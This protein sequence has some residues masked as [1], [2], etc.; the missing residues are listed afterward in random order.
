MGELLVFAGLVAAVAVIGIGA[1]MLVAGR[2]DQRVGTD[3]TPEEA[4]GHDRTDA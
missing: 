1:G 4:G 3:E 2:L